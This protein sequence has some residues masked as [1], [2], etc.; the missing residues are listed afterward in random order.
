MEGLLVKII[1]MVLVL[2]SAYLVNAEKIVLTPIETVV[3]NVTED[4]Q[5]PG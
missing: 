2:F 1:A 3:V 5:Y 4:E